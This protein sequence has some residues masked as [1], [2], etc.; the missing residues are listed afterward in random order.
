MRRSNDW[1]V[2]IALIKSGVPIVGVVH[3]PQ[4]NVTY[5]AESGL[6]WKRDHNTG[7]NKQLVLA[8]FAGNV[9]RMV[10]SQSRGSLDE[11]SVPSGYELEHV[12][13]SSGL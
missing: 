11:L 9:I 4:L 13:M 2:Q 5:Y 8:S 10:T 3:A 7:E 12:R 6:A 1:T